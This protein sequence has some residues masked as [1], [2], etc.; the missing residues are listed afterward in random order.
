MVN[1]NSNYSILRTI[2]AGVPEG[3]ILE[4]ILFNI[5]IS[6]MPISRN[7]TLLIFVYDTAIFTSVNTD[8][9]LIT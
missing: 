8:K 1:I 2:A 5:Y 6:D 7:I 9:T 4:P 3:S